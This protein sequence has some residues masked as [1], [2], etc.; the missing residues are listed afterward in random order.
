L[1]NWDYTILD[2]YNGHSTVTN[3]T[4]YT[5]PFS[6]VW[7]FYGVVM[8]A[9]NATGR[10]LSQIFWN[11]TNQVQSETNAVTTGGNSGCQNW[12]VGPANVGDY[13]EFGVYQ[14]SGAAL[15]TQVA[16]VHASSYFQASILG[17]HL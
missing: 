6:G 4:R 9:V 12:W 14:S 16:A 17:S 10:R 15:S 7:L 5:V 13:F 1:L 2:S 3:P 8:W 11:G